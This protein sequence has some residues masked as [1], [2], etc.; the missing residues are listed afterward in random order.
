MI[1][2]EPVKSET[3]SFAVEPTALLLRNLW[4]TNVKR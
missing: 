4:T 2:L 3:A 1:G